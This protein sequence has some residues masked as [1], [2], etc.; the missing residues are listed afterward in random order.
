MLAILCLLLSQRHPGLQSYTGLL[1]LVDF[2]STIILGLVHTC[3]LKDIDGR[4]PG[5][6]MTTN[7]LNVHGAVSGVHE[8]IDHTRL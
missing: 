8:S 7:I 1:I 2:W 3:P 4:L 5:Y 6:Q